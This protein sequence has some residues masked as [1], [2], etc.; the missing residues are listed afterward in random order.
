MCSFMHALI[1]PWPGG[2]PGQKAIDLPGTGHA[3][4]ARARRRRRLRAGDECDKQQSSA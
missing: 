2:T 3:D 4:A 1:R